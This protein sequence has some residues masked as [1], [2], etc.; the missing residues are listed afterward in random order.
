MKDELYVYSACCTWN[1]PIS[2]TKQYGGPMVIDG[3]AIDA[4][5]PGC[6]HCGSPLMQ[7]N[8]R[9]EWDAALTKFMELHPEVP[10]YREWMATLNGPCRPLKDWDWRAAYAEFVRSITV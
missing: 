9:A 2:Q 1:G 6:P 7:Y 10:L 8:N 4:S 5:I 3:R